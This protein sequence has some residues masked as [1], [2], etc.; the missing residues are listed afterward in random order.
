MCGEST[1]KLRRGVRQRGPKEHV[2][3][4]LRH[5]SVVELLLG[6]SGRSSRKSIDVEKERFVDLAHVRTSGIAKRAH[7]VLRAS[8][9][10][11]AGGLR[12]P[13]GLVRVWWIDGGAAR[14]MCAAWLRTRGQW[15]ALEEAT[16]SAIRR[17]KASVLHRGVR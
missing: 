2:D 9:V 10:E 8:A 11:N 1:E 14:G 17:V 5:R 16:S 13:G 3:E 15:T 4:A 7:E 6:F 12:R